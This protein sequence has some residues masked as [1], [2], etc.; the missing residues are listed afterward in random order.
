MKVLVVG[1]GAR[2]HAIAKA[3]HESQSKPDVYAFM[4][5]NNPGIRK[6]SAQAVVGNTKDAKAVADFAI[7]C[8]VELAVIGPD[9]VLEAGI[10]DALWDAGVPTVGPKKAGARLEWDK[11]FARNLMKKHNIEGCPRF[12]VFKDANEAGKL[13]DELAGEVAVKPSGLTAGKGVKVVGYQ[14]KDASEAK[15]YCKEILSTNMGGLGEVVIEEKLIGQELTLQ[16]FVDGKTV[17]GMPCVQDHKL[18]FEGDKGLMTGGMGS[19]STGKLLPFMKQNEYDK[20]IEII[21]K[22]VAALAAEGIDYRGIIYGQFMITK[23]GPKVVEFNAR[24]GDPE[25]INVLALLETDFVDVCMHVVNGT[26]SERNVVF[27]EY[28]TVVKYLVPEGYPEKPAKG[29]VISIG[30]K[31]INRLG[32]EIYFASVDEKDGVVY[33]GTS[34]AIGVLGVE[35]SLEK[36]ERTCEHA[37]S[38][39]K[40]KLYHRRDIGT[41]T[42]V[43]ARVEQ[44]RKIRGG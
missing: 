23:E 13:I 37:C 27:S 36:A 28:C 14:L 24:F 29:E 9:A 35:D 4:S 5:N 32:A 12:G 1:S 18:A 3:L 22:V 38:F 26:L 40:G 10:A 8:K 15:Q 31:S 44:M 20:C 2:E 19:Y 43:G 7:K 41:K 6:I 33:T 17:R 42:L 11:S 25:A 21:E 30:E 34:R 39:V 16:A